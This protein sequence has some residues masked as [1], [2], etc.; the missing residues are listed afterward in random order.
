[1]CE[2]D[3]RGEARWPVEVALLSLLCLSGLPEGPL[4]VSSPRL[5]RGAGGGD[6]SDNGGLGAK[7]PSS[8]SA[9]IDKERL[10]KDEPSLPILGVGWGCDIL[11]PSGMF[12]EKCAGGSNRH[13]VYLDW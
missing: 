4:L 2:C 8:F 11:P 3:Q 1:M 13:S 10:S 6:A 5:G 12:W 7:S 9:H